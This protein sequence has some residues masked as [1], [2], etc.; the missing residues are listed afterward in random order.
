M[1]KPLIHLVSGDTRPDLVFQVTNKNNGRVVD[2]TSSSISVFMKFRATHSVTTLA[3][4]ACEKTDPESGEC[5]LKWPTGTLDV[6][7]GRY[8]GEVYLNDGGDVQ[9]D[10]EIQKF[11]LRDG[12]ADV[13]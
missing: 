6:A 4:I 2:L 5:T 12:F 8:E 9:S 7:A 3:D 1:S 11:K 10:F 13:T